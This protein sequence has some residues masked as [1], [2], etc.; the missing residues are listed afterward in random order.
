M[1]APPHVRCYC[2]SKTAGRHHFDDVERRM[3]AAVRKLGIA[4]GVVLAGFI[5]S[6][7][8]TMQTTDTIALSGLGSSLGVM[9]KLVPMELHTEHIHKDQWL[10]LILPT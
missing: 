5:V 7:L 1:L 3:N 10:Q 4:A 6:P 8:A 2:W 9:A